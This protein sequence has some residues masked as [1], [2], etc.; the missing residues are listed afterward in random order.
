[1]YINNIYIYPRVNSGLAYIYPHTCIHTYTH[2]YIHGYIR[3][4]LHAYNQ[5]ASM[6]PNSKAYVSLTSR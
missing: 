3:T 5:T 1:M 6:G 2:A 4:Y